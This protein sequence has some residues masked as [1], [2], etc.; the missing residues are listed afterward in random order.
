MVA[1]GFGNP[2]FAMLQVSFLLVSILGIVFWYQDVIAR[3]PRPD[4]LSL[5]EALLT[6]LSFPLLPI[7]TLFMVAI[8][9][10]QAQTRLMIGMPLQ[11]RVT[12]KD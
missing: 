2:T 7:L 12:K 1:E 11:F 6:V 10:L 3:P 8:P 4:K 9:T 5:S